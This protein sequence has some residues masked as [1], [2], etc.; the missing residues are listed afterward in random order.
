VTK[1]GSGVM[2]REIL[3]HSA[4]GYG[5]ENR[6]KVRTS[7]CFKEKTLVLSGDPS[8]QRKEK[9]QSTGEDSTSSKVHFFK[10]WNA[11]QEAGSVPEP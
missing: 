7:Q 4:R 3:V 11:S 2:R 9:E 6:T 5:V 1:L 10:S 8:L